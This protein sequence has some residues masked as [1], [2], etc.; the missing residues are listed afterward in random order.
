M[1]H[2]EYCEITTDINLL[3]TNDL[4]KNIVNSRDLIVVNTEIVNDHQTP[5]PPLQ[6][7]YEIIQCSINSALEL[8]LRLYPRPSRSKPNVY[9]TLHNRK[10]ALSLDRTMILFTVKRW[11]FE[12]PLLSYAKKT[13]YARQPQYKWH[14]IMAT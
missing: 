4:P 1:H 7:K 12:D 3:I 10:Q 9:L 5:P 2:T 13:G 11:G 14:T 8:D 6:T